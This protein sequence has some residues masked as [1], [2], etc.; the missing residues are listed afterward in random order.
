M[1]FIRP[2]LNNIESKSNSGRIKSVNLLKEKEIIFA[3]PGPLPT[4]I[5]NLNWNDLHVKTQIQNN[6]YKAN[7]EHTNSNIESDKILSPFQKELF[8]IINNYED[9]YLP[10]RTLDNGE[11]IK[12]IYCLH[13]V[14]HALKT[15]L[16]VI[17]HNARLSDKNDVPD[18]FRDQGLTRPKVLIIVPFRE[19]AF[20]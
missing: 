4:V 14:N 17:H 2:K 10:N 18:E 19:S 15:R 3:A 12:F 11:E 9:L 13:A 8:S 5:K 20:R 7:L 6:I 1:R 16:K